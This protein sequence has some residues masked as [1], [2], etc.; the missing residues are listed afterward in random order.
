MQ[1]LSFLIV[2]VV[3]SVHI[4]VRAPLGACACLISQAGYAASEQR[5]GAALQACL[6]ARL[7][8]RCADGARMRSLRATL[9][10]A[11]CPAGGTLR[12]SGG[13]STSRQPSGTGNC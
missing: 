9:R 2:R 5:A 7:C 12:A 13:G 6:G 4:V 3:F 11:C 1:R 10:G 8:S